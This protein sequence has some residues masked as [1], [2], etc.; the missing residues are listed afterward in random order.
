MPINVS[1]DE[2][3]DIVIKSDVPVMVD[4]FAAWCG[5]CK[6]IAPVIEEIS[7]SMEGRA[8]IVKI[9]VDTSAG[10]ASKYEI[11]GV[12][13]LIYFKNGEVSDRIIGVAPKE[14]MLEKLEGLLDL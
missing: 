14:V 9:D 3:E 2:F 13:T 11:T 4:F 10:L 7:H 8:K 12:P 5:P 6:M 1:E